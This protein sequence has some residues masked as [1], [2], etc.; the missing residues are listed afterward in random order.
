MRWNLATGERERISDHRFKPAPAVCPSPDGRWVSYDGLVGDASEC[1]YWLYDKQTGLE[2]LYGRFPTRGPVPGAASPGIPRFAP[3]GKQ[4]ATYAKADFRAAGVPGTVGGLLVFESESLAC[5]ALGN[6]SV[7]ARDENRGHVSLWWSNDGKYVLLMAIS[8]P[9][10]RILRE[11]FA[12]DVRA[13]RFEQID[14]AYRDDVSFFRSGARIEHVAPPP[15][16]PHAPNPRESRSA[17][18]Q[19]SAL[20][21]A[22]NELVVVSGAGVPR[23]VHAGRPLDEPPAGARGGVFDNRI[24]IHGWLDR[25]HLVYYANG[26]TFVYDANS[27]RAAALFAGGQHPAR[28]PW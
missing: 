23:A 20:V 5:A 12:L 19:W 22:A 9:A 21:S 1:Q 11:Y 15:L 7:H 6:P 16:P 25:R 27:D 4:I 24:L 26:S 2:R 17:D 10:G 8:Y 3:N 14:G 18:G 13:S 28:Y